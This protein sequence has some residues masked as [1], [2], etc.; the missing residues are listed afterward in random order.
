TMRSQARGAELEF[1]GHTTA[2]ELRRMLCDAK[3]TPVVLGGDGQP[4]DVGREKRCVTPAQRKAIAARDGGC[5][6]PGCDRTP[7][8]CQ[9]HHIHTT[10]DIGCT[11]AKPTSTISSCS[12]A[13]TTA[14]ST[15]PTGQYEY[16]T[17]NPNSFHHDGSISAKH[18][19]ATPAHW[20]PRTNALFGRRLG[21]PD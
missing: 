1:G 6:H 7:I 13:N 19:A 10:S 9:I 14:P 2:G 4:L 18:P 17:A 16:A 11:A 5:A 3:I 15:T 12:A 8:W 20:Y 21:A